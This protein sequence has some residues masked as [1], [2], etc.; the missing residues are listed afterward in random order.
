M[1]LLCYTRAR[2]LP[3]RVKDRVFFKEGELKLLSL[4]KA[5]VYFTTS[6]RSNEVV[7]EKLLR[8]KSIKQYSKYKHGIIKRTS[9][10]N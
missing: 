9:T 3:E 1:V 2:K 6:L 10:Q 7:L 4:E 5:L 8:N